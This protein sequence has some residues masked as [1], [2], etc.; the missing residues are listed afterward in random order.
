MNSEP[1]INRGWRIMRRLLIGLAVLATLAAI[2]YTE[3]NWRGRRAWEKCKSEY[4]AKGWVFDWKAYIPPPVP[5][6]HNFYK[7]P[8]MAEW[9]V[10]PDWRT[11]IGTNELTV[12]LANKLT[13]TV[14][15]NRVDAENYLKWSDGLEPQF[16]LIREALKRPYARIDCDYS[17]PHLILIPH[18]VTMR[19]LAQ[20]LALAVLLGSAA[21]PGR[22]RPFA[23]APCCWR[24]S[25]RALS[26]TL[27]RC[28]SLCRWW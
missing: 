3:E 14:I 17:I 16:A 7:A 24:C 27:S 12:L 8:K 19:S 15:T 22:S 18:F 20:V 5:D 9:F 4:E 21:S 13:T 11:G 28:S 2:F 10:K 26:W 23:P 25:F 6:D 1:Q